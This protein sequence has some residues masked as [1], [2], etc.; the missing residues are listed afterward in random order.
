MIDFQS[1]YRRA[2]R[3]DAPALAELVNMAGEGLPLYVWSQM[4]EGGKS[5]W[6]VGRERAMRESGGFSYRNAVV[7]VQDDRVVAGLIGYPLDDTPA[8]VDYSDIPAMF[9]PLQQLEDLAPGTW[10]VNVLATYPEYRG[11]GYGRELLAMAEAL[12]QDLGKHGLSI[13]VADSNTAAR[14]LYERQGYAERARR[15][16]IKATWQH[17]GSDWVLMLKTL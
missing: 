14:R 11:R 17:P 6:D 13:I 4:T 10:Y 2:I 5:P 7:R 16:M 8:P 15:P 3:A 1:P 9:V 12:A